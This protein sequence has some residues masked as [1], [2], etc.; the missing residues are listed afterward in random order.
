MTTIAGRERGR[1]LSRVAATTPAWTKLGRTA[2]YDRQSVL[3]W[4]ERNQLNLEREQP[5]IRRRRAR[6]RP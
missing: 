5:P 3:D 2:L 4:L 1:P 6:R